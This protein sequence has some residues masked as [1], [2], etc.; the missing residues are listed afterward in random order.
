MGSKQSKA[1]KAARKAAKAAAGGQPAAPKK[2]TKKQRKRKAREDAAR[3]KA[4][5]D[6]AAED[7]R[8]RERAT[9]HRKERRELAKKLG[10]LCDGSNGSRPPL[11]SLSLYCALHPSKDPSDPPP[12]FFSDT[13]TTTTTTTNAHRHNCEMWASPPSLFSLSFPLHPPL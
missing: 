10:E 5:A 12:A 13:T 3:Q 4:E 6:T 1:D 2:L 7:A 8:L 9:A 11:L